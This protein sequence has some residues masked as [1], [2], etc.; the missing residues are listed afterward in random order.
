MRVASLAL[1]LLLALSAPAAASASAPAPAPAE[2]CQAEAVGTDAFCKVNGARL[3]YVDWGG[4]GPP[5]ILLA[6]FGDTARAF[7]SLAPRLASGRHVYAFTRRG[8][9]LSEQTPGT[10]SAATF[11]DDIVAMMDDLGIAR[12]DL[13]GHSVAGAELVMVARDHPNRVRRLVYLDAAYDRSTALKMEAEDP[14]PRK[15][16]PSDLSSYE[17]LASWRAGALGVPPSAIENN[18]RQLFVWSG[19]RLTP[20]SGPRVITDVATGGLLAVAPDYGAIAAP[21]LALYAPK[22]Q[23]E[24]LPAGAR[25]SD[26]AASVAYGLRRIRP[27][28]LREQARFLETAPCGVALE[29]PG[30][31]HFVHLQRSEWV[32][33]LILSFLNTGSPCDWRPSVSPLPSPGL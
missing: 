19:T 15:P 10:Y 6:G 11:A 24:Q 31:T 29:V 2:G 1:A 33:G 25:D 14:A 17:A 27:W 32:A 21:S 28:M 7:D 23:P 3:H 16:S 22:D 5:L 30:A 18:V 4:Q 8:F 9:G 13:V 12:A 26:R 20:R